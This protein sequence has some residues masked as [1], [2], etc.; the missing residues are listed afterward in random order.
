VRPEHLRFANDALGIAGT[1][2]MSLPLG[3]TIVHEMRTPSGLS[4]K[5]S[6]RRSTSGE[7]PTPGALV[8][9]QPIAPELVNVFR[10]TSDQ[11]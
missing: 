11:C 10:D 8:T 5:V 3:S 7:P 1:V 4:L 6:E 2:E 9:V